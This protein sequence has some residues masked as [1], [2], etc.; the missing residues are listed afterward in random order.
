MKGTQKKARDEPLD[1]CKAAWNNCTD[2][3]VTINNS[4]DPEYAA[5]PP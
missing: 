3:K 2:H 1:R 4:D 5:E